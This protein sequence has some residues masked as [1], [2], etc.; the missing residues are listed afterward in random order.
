MFSTFK[1]VAITAALAT[2]ATASVGANAA[3]ESGGTGTNAN[4]IDSEL[5]LTVW[6]TDS[7]KSFT[8]D[9]GVTTRQFMTGAATAQSFNLDAGGL[10]HIGTGNIQWSVAGNSSVLVGG[11]LD[12]YGFYFTSSNSSPVV[13]SNNA[14]VP[15]TALF[16]NFADYE[17]A[18]GAADSGTAADPVFFLEGAQNAGAGNVW[19]NQLR[20]TTANFGGATANGADGEAMTAWTVGLNAT[21]T[22]GSVKDSGPFFWA[23]DTDLG[24][25][26]YTAVPIPA[27]A[28]LFGSALLG[29]AGA[30]RRRKALQA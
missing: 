19:G 6:N 15:L 16:P 21:A 25:L 30:A 12:N 14:F 1:K 10:A 3:W 26:E 27:A 13:T 9:L 23:L 7:S 2:A 22:G 28:W 5:V 18:L 8:Q 29:M 4:P 17:T 11:E 24:S 20:S